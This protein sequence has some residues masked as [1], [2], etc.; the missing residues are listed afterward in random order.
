MNEEQYPVVYHSVFIRI[1]MLGKMY[2]VKL[3]SF[4]DNDLFVEVPFY[5]VPM[6]GFFL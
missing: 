3:H 6:N 4:G 2:I 5:F 1:Y